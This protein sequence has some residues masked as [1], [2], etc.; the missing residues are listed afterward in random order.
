MS[1]I[2]N[3]FLIIHTT[4]WINQ[5]NYAGWNDLRQKVHGLWFHL[6]KILENVNLPIVT[7]R[8]LPEV[9]RGITKG[10]KKSFGDDEYVHCFDYSDG[11]TDVYIC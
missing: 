10:Q 5:N 4:T 1:V 3:V 8:W 6:Y 7:E 11:F 9:K 2:K